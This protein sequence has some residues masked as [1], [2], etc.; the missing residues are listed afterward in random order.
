VMKIMHIIDVSFE[1]EHGKE[2]PLNKLLIADEPWTLQVKEFYG[3]NLRLK[4]KGRAASTIFFDSGFPFEG[5]QVI[6]A[7]DGIA[8]EVSRTVEALDALL[9]G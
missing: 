8:K 7:L 4:N 5:K 1:D 9:F 6:P 2:W 3:K